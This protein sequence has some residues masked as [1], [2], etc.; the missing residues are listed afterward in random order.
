MSNQA[1]HRNDAI[2]A[3]RSSQILAAA[4]TVFAEKGYQDAT[5]DEI[6]E[7]AGVAKGTLYSYFPSKRD[8]YVAE[9]SRGSAE[10]LDLTRKAIES[11]G[12]TRAKIHRFIHGRLEF[13]DSHLEFFQI[14]QLEFGQ[15]THPAF[16]SEQFRC[17]YGQQLQMLEGLLSTAAE[18][19]EI[20]PLPA[21]VLATG[22]YEMT[23]GLLLRRVLGMARGSVEAEAEAL[24]DL[25]WKGIGKE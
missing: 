25:L 1:K 24:S 14:Y 17:T 3:F 15:V 6:A 11:P 10:L 19:G 7:R 4:R 16:V 12:D 8:V 9:L 5:M 2:C 22:I 21:G 13:L 20:R 23:R 18:R